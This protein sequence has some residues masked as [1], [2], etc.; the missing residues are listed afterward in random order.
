VIRGA[1]TALLA[2]ALAAAGAAIAQ[3]GQVAFV[4][5][6][7]VSFTVTPEAFAA[8][9]A[10]PGCEPVAPDLGN[11]IVLEVTRQNPNRLYTIDVLHDG[12]GPATDLPLEARYTVTSTNGQTVF[13]TTAWTPIDAA[14]A[15]VFTQ[16]AVQRENRVRVEVAYRLALRGDEPAGSFVTRVTHRVRENGVAVAH[17]VRVA[18]PSFLSLRVVGRTP[19]VASAVVAFDYA[20]LPGA[21]LQAVTAGA[22]LPP[23]SQDLARVEVATNHPSGYTVTA[24]VEELLAPAGAPSF[25]GRLWLAGAPAQGR[26]FVGAGPTDG[27]ITIATGDD[28]GLRVDGFE[29]PGAYLFSVTFEAVRNP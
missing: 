13:L 28:Y 1:R 11:A 8:A 25:D 7:P 15:L 2:L 10:C 5:A 6:G 21:Y 12:W 27:F 29:A 18:I 26:T 24:R 3:E 4:T 22:P 17:E 20:D 19:G 16:A 14:P 23:T 9:G